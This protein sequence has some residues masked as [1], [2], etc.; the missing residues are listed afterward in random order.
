MEE[1]MEEDVEEDVEEDD[2]VG[3]CWRGDGEQQIG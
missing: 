1:D 2:K 3:W